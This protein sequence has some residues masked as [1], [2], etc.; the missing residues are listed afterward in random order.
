MTKFI[1]HKKRS[2]GFTLIELLV[3]ISIIGLLSVIVLSSL[4]EARTRAQNTK[5]NQIAMQYVTAFNLMTND[6]TISFP[7]TNEGVSICLG[8][9]DAETCAPFTNGS[10]II[11]NKLINYYPAMPKNEEY[12]V[13]G[14]SGILYTNN[15]S[16]KKIDWFLNGNVSCPRGATPTAQLGITICSYSF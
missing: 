9:E 10:T 13:L 6:G 12:E 14:A 5:L 16:G 15:S 1:H 2:S 8:Y 4:T 7:P 11:K 3:V